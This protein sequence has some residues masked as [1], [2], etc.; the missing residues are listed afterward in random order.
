MMHEFCE[1]P[2][3]PSSLPAAGARVDDARRWRLTD[4]SP[5]ARH[6]TG[7][8]AGR[9]EPVDEQHGVSTDTQMSAQRFAFRK[10]MLTVDA[11][12]PARRLW[13]HPRHHCR[14][15]AGFGGPCCQPR[16]PGRS[17]VGQFEKA[18]GLVC[19]PG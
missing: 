1:H 6:R 19:Y 9:A 4:A 3:V 8:S 13:L 15:R 10:P 16:R 5:S 7:M 18:S 17:G 2:Q 14:C 11:T 12:R